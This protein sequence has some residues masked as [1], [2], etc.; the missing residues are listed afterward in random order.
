MVLTCII[1]TALVLLVMNYENHV[2]FSRIHFSNKD[3]LFYSYVS[4]TLVSFP[5][6]S[7]N[8]FPGFSSQNESFGG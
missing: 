3:S 6:Y 4:Y 7:P 8:F 1:W 5:P 2:D